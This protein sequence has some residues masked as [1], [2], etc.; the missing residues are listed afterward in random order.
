LSCRP[1]TD[2]YDVKP[3]STCNCCSCQQQASS[4]KQQAVTLV[5]SLHNNPATL[6]G[7][8]LTQR[9]LVELRALF[10]QA[11]ASANG[12]APSHTTS[13]P[14]PGLTVPQL[15]IIVRSLGGSTISDWE[16]QDWI[17]EIDVNDDGGSFDS[18]QDGGGNNESLNEKLVDFATFVQIMTRDLRGV[19]ATAE[20]GGSVT[21]RGAD[22]KAVA[23]TF[24]EQDLRTMHKAFRRFDANGRGR[25]GAAD[26]GRLF[27]ELGHAGITARELDEM[28][29]EVSK[30]GDGLIGFE[31]FVRTMAP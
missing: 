29:T 19:D 15:A 5:I 4:Y 16:V 21:S 20:A 30:T 18:N 26:L 22:V 23:V 7:H 11:C 31:D 13:T 17:S 10:D 3:L 9:Q 27:A 1:P 8:L 2:E 28:V 25:I 14:A 24:S 12:A 6:Q